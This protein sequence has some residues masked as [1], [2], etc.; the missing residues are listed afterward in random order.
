MSSPL[1]LVTGDQALSTELLSLLVIALIAALTPLLVASW[2][3]R[4]SSS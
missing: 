2:L 3:P 4:T 1:F